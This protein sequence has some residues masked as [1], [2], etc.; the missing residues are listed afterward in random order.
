MSQQSP[1]IPTSLIGLGA[2]G[3]SIARNLHRAGLL[4]A[5]WNRTRTHAEPLA[6]QYGLPLVEDIAATAQA[7]LII[8]CVSGDTDLLEVI[9]R[10]APALDPGR[11]LLDCSTVSTETAREAARRLEQRGLAFVDGPV[12]GGTEGAR[13][14]RLVMMAG[15]DA[16]VIERL[17]PTLAAFTRSVTHMGPVGAGQASKAVNQVMAAGI[18][19]AVCQALAFG[20]AQ[21]LDMPRV[22]DVVSGGAAGNW[23]LEHRGKTMLAGRYTP[24]FKV[25][26]HLKDL[27]ICQQMAQS[28]G[29]DLPLLEQ[30]LADY[31]RLV[32]AGHGEED[33][34][35]LYRL[36]RP[37]GER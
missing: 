11:T 19:Q 29:L 25:T 12:S 8:T 23:F 6:E 17:R 22:V 9:D 4:Q 32:E 35:A 31:R 28:Q 13:K 34:S 15:G 33:I 27:L 2:M 36:Q 21:G 20:Q 5:A 18:N 14:G 30:T 37:G 1:T 7:G 26:L 24:G 10:L 16:G 3:G